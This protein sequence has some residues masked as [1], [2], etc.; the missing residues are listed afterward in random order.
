LLI[1]ID[2]LTR[3]KILE[4]KS[5]TQKILFDKNIIQTRVSQVA[6]QIALWFRNKSEKN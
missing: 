5:L 3:A 1:R 6:Q 2:Y 4:M